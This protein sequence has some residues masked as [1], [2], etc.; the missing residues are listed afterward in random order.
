[1]I[2]WDSTFVYWF[3]YFVIISL[4]LILMSRGFSPNSILSI[5]NKNMRLTKLYVY[6]LI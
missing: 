5:K 4:S 3:N 6:N 1:M 2:Y